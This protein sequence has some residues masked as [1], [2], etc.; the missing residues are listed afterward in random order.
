MTTYSSGRRAAATISVSWL[1]TPNC[2]SQGEDVDVLEDMNAMH[3]KIAGSCDVAT[4]LA[5][6][7][8]GKSIG[9]AVA[10]PRREVDD[11]ADRRRAR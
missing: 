10:K 9:V 11:R 4:A 6:D 7:T 2:L 1:T 8:G 3:L 5:P